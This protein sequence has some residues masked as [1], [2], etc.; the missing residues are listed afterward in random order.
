MK[1]RTITDPTYTIY[2]KGGNVEKAMPAIGNGEVRQMLMQM[3]EARKDPDAGL[4][5]ELL[6]N[7]KKLRDEI[8]PEE[9]DLNKFLDKLSDEQL[10]R[11][12]LKDGGKVIDFLKFAKSKEPRVKKIDLAS[13]FTP[14]K[15]LASLTDSERDL[16]ND[17]LRR[18]LKNI[19]D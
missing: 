16:V 3:A 19:K 7:I 11:L 8:D 6:Q 5:I 12:L 18:T 1:T 17:L 15:T 2:K 13:Q 14:G 10:K 9:K 4:G